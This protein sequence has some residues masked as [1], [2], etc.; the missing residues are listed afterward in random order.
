MKKIWDDKNLLF[1]ANGSTDKYKKLRYFIVGGL[2]LADAALEM[3]DLTVDDMTPQSTSNML[4][5]AFSG[6]L[7]IDN[8]YSFG[9]VLI[10]APDK[11][12]YDPWRL[13]DFSIGILIVISSILGIF[14]VYHMLMLPFGVVRIVRAVRI[15]HWLEDRSVE[16]KVIISALIKSAVPLCYVFILIGIFLLYFSLAAIMLFK[17]ANPQRFGDLQIS[18]IS[19][20][21]VMTTDNWTDMMRVCM[22]GCANYGYHTGEIK[23][24]NACTTDGSGMGYISPLFFMAW[25]VLAAMLLASLLIGE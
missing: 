23:Y 17:D 14:S 20:L 13:F 1:Y 7:L 16:L 5:I 22:I 15:L 12:F 4:H 8:V 9:P 3:Y 25:I 19:L 18:L 6:V 11:V 10:T 24:D 21:Q 2:I